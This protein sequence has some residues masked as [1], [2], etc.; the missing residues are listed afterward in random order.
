MTYESYFNILWQTGACHDRG[1]YAR[2][3]TRDA[4]RQWWGMSI[5]TFWCI[6]IQVFWLFDIVPLW[7]SSGVFLAT[8]MT[9]TAMVWALYLRIRHLDRD[10][11]RDDL[12]CSGL[13][14]ARPF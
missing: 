14:T 8:L 3:M 7:V 4:R 5:Q 12:S 6:L 11:P 9:F 2:I 1:Q 13:G 10:E